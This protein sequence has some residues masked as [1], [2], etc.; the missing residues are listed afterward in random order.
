MPEKSRQVLFVGFGENELGK[1][2][3]AL[4]GTD[5]TIKYVRKGSSALKMINEGDVAV[6]VDRVRKNSGDAGLGI[7]QK[8]RASAPHVRLVAALDPADSFNQ[9]R[10]RELGALPLIGPTDANVLKVTLLDLF[11]QRQPASESL[12]SASADDLL[13][14]ARRIAATEAKNNFAG[15]LDGVMRGEEV[16]ITKHNSA[17]AVVLSVE[18]FRELSKGSSPDL[19]A[20]TAEFNTRLERMQRPQVRAAIQSAFDASPEDLGRVALAAARPR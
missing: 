3:R 10:V 13:P 7:L 19:G 2:R 17:K 11:R 15:V 4:R 6:V 18:K 9:N 14:G 1:A 8:V 12:S 5:L 16:I 20:L